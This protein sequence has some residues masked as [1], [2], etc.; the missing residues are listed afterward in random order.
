MISNQSPFANFYD[1]IFATSSQKEQE[2]FLRQLFTLDGS[3][4]SSYYHYLNFISVDQSIKDLIASA[5]EEALAIRKKILAYDWEDLFQTVP[6]TPED[7][8]EDVWKI[9]REDFFNDILLWIKTHFS[10]GDILMAFKKM[11]VL[12]LSLDFDW[13]KDLAE[14]ACYYQDE[15][16]SYEVESEFNHAHA[17]SGDSIFSVE[18]L[19]KARDLIIN[20][21]GNPMTYFPHTENWKE[22]LEG[23]D[24]RLKKLK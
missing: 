3:L 15:I 7:Y 8:I 2:I 16:N 4:C 14:P 12:E 22:L 17:Y 1:E 11:R 19:E 10:H 20:F 21:M 18:I 5:E 24:D 23:I 6:G 9:L 13:E